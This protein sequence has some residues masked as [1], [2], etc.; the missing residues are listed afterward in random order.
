MLLVGIYDDL[1][2]SRAVI[3]LFAQVA[4]ASIVYSMGIRVEAITVPFF[5]P[6][7]FGWMSLPVTIF[8][9]VLVMNA[10]NL[11]DGLDGLAGGVVVLAGST[12]FIM[13]VIED[14][15]VAALL[16][17]VIVGSTLGFLLQYNMNPPVSFWVTLAV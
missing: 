11:I 14:D 8:W 5:E 3:K 1:R 17:V 4:A 13:S 15:P 16:L 10:I 7:R 9:M 6:I 12:L 2:G